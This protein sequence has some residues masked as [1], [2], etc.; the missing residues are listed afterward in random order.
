MAHSEL[1]TDCVE[2][3]GTELLATSSLDGFIRIWSLDTFKLKT[4]LEDIESKKNA[5]K[6]VIS[7]T[8]TV[9]SAAVMNI[10]G[11]RSLSYTSEFGG[12][13]VS[14]GYTNYINV[15]SPASS[16]SKAYIGKLEGHTGIVLSC[17]V[18]SITPN[19]LSI[20]DKFTIKIWDIRNFVCLQ[21][22]RSESFDPS[23][24]SCISVIPGDSRFLVGGKKLLLYTNEAMQKDQQAFDEELIPFAT[25]FNPYF[26]TFSVITKNDIR[27][28]DAFTGKL[29]KVLADLADL[30]SHTEITSFQMGPRNRKFFLA[31]NTGNCKVYNVKSGEMLTRL[32][33]P[34]EDKKDKKEDKPKAIKQETIQS[35]KAREIVRIIFVEAQGILIVGTCDATVKVYRISSASDEVEL[36]R[37]IRGAHSK[38]DLTCLE[39]SKETLTLYTAANDGTVAC[40][41]F[42]SSKII[43]YYQDDSSDITSLSDLFPYPAL[44]VGNS[45][46]MITCWKTKDAKRAYPMVFKINIYDQKCALPIRSIGSALTL[47]VTQPGSRVTN[48]SESIRFNQHTYDEEVTKRQFNAQE[49]EPFDLEGIHNLHVHMGDNQRELRNG[50]EKFLLLVGSGNGYLQVHDLDALFKRND[51]VPLSLKE[52]NER[53]FEKFKVSLYRK[54]SVNGENCSKLLEDALELKPKREKIQFYLDSSIYI[55]SW[56]AHKDIVCSLNFISESIEGFISSSSDWFIKIWSPSGVMHC[57]VNI[58][59]PRHTTWDFPYDWTRLI[60]KDLDEVFSIV[61]KLDRI[62]IGPKQREALQIRY[63]YNNFLL[64]EFSKKFP[65]EPVDLKYNVLAGLSIAQ[66]VQTFSRFGE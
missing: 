52:Y 49:L 39:Y 63:L 3:S 47:K 1:I 62:E 13:L 10:S 4:E 24:V 60:L 46:G 30:K 41:S 57:Q 44:L 25:C 48:T 9:K 26:N 37:E 2:I 45:R 56:R 15:W 23:M 32:I 55:R 17:K 58:L 38:A 18:F 51:I 14:C 19:C 42:E 65:P 20:D 35:R 28:Y 40:W 6:K 61:E 27:V 66:K 11:V 7:Q 36:L 34:E 54:D 43:A 29:K 64:P 22:I 50:R 8:E 33:P 12:N 21:T 16:L 5:T 53:R 59:D 31:D